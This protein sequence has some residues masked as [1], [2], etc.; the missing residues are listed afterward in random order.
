[1]ICVSVMLAL[2]LGWPIAFGGT[3]DGGREPRAGARQ[4]TA[5]APPKRPKP[6][7]VSF[8]REGDRPESC[9]SLFQHATRLCPRGGIGAVACQQEAADDWDLCEARGF[10]PE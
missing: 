3:D 2:L 10:W 1:M 4:V 9:A 8:E 6:M 5:P 7:P